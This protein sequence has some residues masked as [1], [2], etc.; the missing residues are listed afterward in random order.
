MSPKA[1]VSP[2]FERAC[3]QEPERG[4]SGPTALN[5]ISISFHTRDP[6][7]YRFNADTSNQINVLI[8]QN[9]QVKL[10]KDTGVVGKIW[11]LTVARTYPT[12]GKLASDLE[13]LNH[14]RT[15]AKSERLLSLLRFFQHSP[16]IPDTG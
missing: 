11:F 8:S 15:G 3:A 1:S 6:P 12:V 4:K 16:E 13:Y 7:K 14:F 2:L 10:A 9:G 5:P